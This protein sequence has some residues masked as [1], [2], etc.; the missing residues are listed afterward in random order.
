MIEPLAFDFDG[1]RKALKAAEGD[2]GEPAPDTHARMDRAR[3]AARAFPSRPRTIPA[4][5]E[6][7]RAFARA[8]L[9]V[10]PDAT[11]GPISMLEA[12][13]TIVGAFFEAG[14]LALAV[15]RR[16]CLAGAPAS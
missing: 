8:V 6:A 10:E 16:S 1:L 3:T 14:A 2:A 7:L 15:D 9:K 4:I 11:D 5:N 12:G 13:D